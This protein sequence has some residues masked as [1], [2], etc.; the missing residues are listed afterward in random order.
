MANSNAHEVGGFSHGTSY[1]QM[2]F[3]YVI[4]KFKS[5]LPWFLLPKQRN[6]QAIA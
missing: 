4:P 1:L 3:T 6:Q 2:E 5:L